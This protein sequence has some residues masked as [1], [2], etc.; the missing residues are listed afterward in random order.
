[1]KTRSLIVL[2]VVAVVVAVVAVFA[3]QDR[4]S[5]TRHRVVGERLFPGLIERVNSV[6]SMEVTQ[7]EDRYTIVRDGDVWGL[8]EKGGYPAQFDMVKKTI[9]GIAE[10][11]LIEAKT[12]KRDRLGELYLAEPD[13]EEGPGT[14][15]ALRGEDG[16]ELAAMILGKAARGG[17]GR[18]YV[19]RAGEDQAWLAEV[20]VDIG[21]QPMDWVDK[22]MTKLRPDRLRRVSITHDDDGDDVVLEKTDKENS[23]FTVP[24]LP[25]GAKVKAAMEI[26]GIVSALSFLNIEDVAPVADIAFE[27]ETLVTTRYETFDGLVIT[28]TSVTVGDI[29]W[30]RFEAAYDAAL[31]EPVEEAPEEDE[32]EAEDGV[33]LPPGMEEITALTAEDVQAE[34][35]A[36]T[37]KTAGWAFAL[38]NFRAVH[39][40]KKLTAMI[41]YPEAEPEFA[42]ELAPDA[43]GTITLP[44]NITIEDLLAGEKPDAA[45][46]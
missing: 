45:Q 28:L 41:E 6:T 29:V 35:A 46:E 4:E 42:D 33:E 30:A 19:R 25:E 15:I 8:A 11:A 20:A 17:G 40:R 34:A 32:A 9:L 21:A 43:S 24:V 3:V 12:S 39:L 44:P 18:R 23:N 1:M 2:A 13:A 10:V 22:T 16:A 36:L 27:G 5:G 37:T 38:P 7:G 14:R 26:N 31:A